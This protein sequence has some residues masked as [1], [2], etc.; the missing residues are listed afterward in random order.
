MPASATAPQIHPAHAANM[1]A[2]ADRLA[3]WIHANLTTDADVVGRLDDTD[4]ERIADVM[5]ETTPSPATR[6]MT[7]VLL[8]SLRA[9][10]IVAARSAHSDPFAG[11]PKDDAM[12]PPTAPEPTRWTREHAGAYFSDCERYCIQDMRPACEVGPWVITY[13]PKGERAGFGR[14]IVRHAD[15]L[16]QAKDDVA[17]H[18]E[19]GEDFWRNIPHGEVRTD[20]RQHAERERFR[21]AGVDYWRKQ[22]PA[23]GIDLT[24]MANDEWVQE[25]AIRIIRATFTTEAAAKRIVAALTEET[26]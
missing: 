12:T 6:A 21:Q 20:A 18:I 23:E 5:G 7:V 8:R 19:H 25:D 15:T 13:D 22:L 3:R 16:R 24:E 11:L 14:M 2:K 1:A 17:A 26:R 9:A 4:W 10:E